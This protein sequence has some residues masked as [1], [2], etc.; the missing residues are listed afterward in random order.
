M[1]KMKTTDIED[2]GNVILI[3]IP[4]SKTRKV[5]S[6]TLIGENYLKIYRKYAEL[7]PKNLPET[8]F[9]LKYQSGKCYRCVMGI[10]SISRV[11][12]KVATLLKLCNAQEYTGHSLRRTS[13]TLLIDG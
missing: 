7:R 11:P 12:G 2:M 6:F 10:H 3:K 8:R 13:A 9:F 4:D 5:R 1:V